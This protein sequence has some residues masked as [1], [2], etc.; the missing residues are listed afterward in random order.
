MSI[1]SQYK[2]E[3]NLEVEG[4]WFA[5]PQ[6]DGSIVELLIARAG[7]SNSAYK[8]EMR[9]LLRKHSRKGSLDIPIDQYP[10]AQRDVIDMM[11]TTILKGARTTLADGEVKEA[12]I[13]EN[14]DW[15]QFNE[16]CARMLL[17]I[18]DL[19]SEIRFKAADYKNFQGEADLGEIEGN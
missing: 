1:V 17:E 10:P 14:G 8:R 3:Q 6:L 19:Q 12:I 15:H 18:P 4:R 5:F 11:A 7:G 16:A 9:R 2:T 13:D